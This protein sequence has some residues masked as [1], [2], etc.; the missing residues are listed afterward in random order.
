MG[1]YVFYPLNVFVFV[2]QLKWHALLARSKYY[3][4]GLMQS[5]AVITRSNILR[6][7]INNYKNWG[8]ISIRCWLKKRHPIPRPYGRAMRCLLWIFVKKFNCVITA[9][10]STVF[11]GLNICPNLTHLFTKS[12]KMASP[13][14]SLWVGIS[15]WVGTTYNL[16]QITCNLHGTQIP[17]I[18]LCSINVI[19]PWKTFLVRCILI[20]FVLHGQLI[21]IIFPVNDTWLHWQKNIFSIMIGLGNAVLPNSR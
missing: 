9:L 7:Y 18:L 16:L 11:Y 5:N 21:G 15:I 19:A 3:I 1:N 4:R 17:Y 8:R 13:S 12:N 2:S 6:D 10:H 14:T 20:S